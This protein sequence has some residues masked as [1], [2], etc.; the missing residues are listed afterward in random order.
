MDWCPHL[1]THHS[2]SY[3]AIIEHIYFLY[4]FKFLI[5]LI[6]PLCLLLIMNLLIIHDYFAYLHHLQNAQ[7]FIP[8]L[9]NHFN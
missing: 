6:C 5:I 9:L 2:C 4:A 7:I 8:P 1:N 3:F